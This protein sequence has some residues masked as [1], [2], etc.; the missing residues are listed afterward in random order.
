MNSN[1]Q[2]SASILSADFSKLGEEVDRVISAGADM[3]HLDVMDGMFVPNI[4]IG[5]PVIKSIR[6]RTGKLFDTHLMIEKP[7]RYIKAFKEAGAD[8]L[9]VQ[10]ESSPHLQRTLTAI[11]EAGM[12]CGVAV[13]PATPVDFLEYI[14]DIVDLV[15]IMTVNP[16]F[17]GQ[18]FI[19]TT[20]PKIRKTREMINISK[21][22][23]YLEVDGGIN[24]KTAGIVTEAGADLL[25]AGSSIFHSNDY[26][27][28][29]DSLK[30]PG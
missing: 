8:I 19:E 12:K 21:R 11:K 28:I 29:I 4:T 25:V 7:E 18:N 14:I 10:V 30:N 5:T 20:I 15:L 26:K 16:G 23:I 13:N 17:G 22:K 24:P 6:Q 2:I 1:I 27:T 9:T 3:I